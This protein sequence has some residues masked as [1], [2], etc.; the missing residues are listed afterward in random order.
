MTQR[1]E[2]ARLKEELERME[3]EPL[4]RAE[5]VLIAGSI[6]LGLVLL[7]VFVLIFRT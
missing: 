2:D 3:Y 5:K 4:M 7:V 6:L 1:E